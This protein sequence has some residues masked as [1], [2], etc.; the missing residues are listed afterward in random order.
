MSIPHPLRALGLIRFIYSVVQQLIAIS[1]RFWVPW[2]CLL[3][4][5][6]DEVREEK[7]LD[8]SSNEVVTKYKAAAE[9]LNSK[10]AL[11]SLIALA[12]DCVVP[13][14]G[15]VSVERMVVLSLRAS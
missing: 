6:D 13:V 3:Q 8:L 2:W 14:D 4:M 12:A 15:R 7:E 1:D 5:S 10:L 11:S 9:I